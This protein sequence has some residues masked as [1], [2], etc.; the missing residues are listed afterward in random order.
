[1][2]VLDPNLEEAVTEAAINRVTST[3]TQRGGVVESQEA[4][5]RRRLAYPIGRTRDGNYILWRLKLDAPA[6][7]EVERQL[8]LMES[9]IRHLLVRVEATQPAAVAAR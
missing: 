8:K 7:A 3:V 2:V 1:M 4:W 9:V 5:G 6:V